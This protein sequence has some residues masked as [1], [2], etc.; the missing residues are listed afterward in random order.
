MMTSPR[1]LLWLLA[2]AALI[3][4]AVPGWAAESYPAKP[5]R[6]IVPFP[7]GGN[8]D[9]VA[10]TVAQK[11][12]ENLGQQ[13]LVDNRGGAG[14][15]IGTQL[16]ARAL[17]DGYT[18]L[19]VSASHVINPGLRRLPYDSVR[20]FSAITVVAEV[21]ILLVVHPSLPARSVTDLVALARAKP[22]QINY[23]SGGS[24]TTAHLAAELLKGAAGVNLVHVPYKGTGPALIDLL[25]GHVTVMFAAMPSVVPHVK[26]GKLRALALVAAKRS[27]ALPALPTIAEAGIPGVEASVGFTLLTPA[28]TPEEIITRLNSEVVRILRLP[29]VAER[30]ASEGAVAVGNSS[31]EAARFIAAEIARWGR[32]T[33]ALGV[34]AD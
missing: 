18:L 19:M 8:T 28:S 12:A 25:A 26:Q 24:G 13:V 15:V 7:P 1:N 29:E 5:L 11:L 22:G 27:P 3:T 6:L 30:L 9:I 4:V 14:G 31:P 34:R 17:P 23:A 21:P 20:D 32:V 2:V 10:R 33:K 16:T